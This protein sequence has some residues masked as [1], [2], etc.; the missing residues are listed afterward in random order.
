MEYKKCVNCSH[1]QQVND[2]NIY[3]D[4]AGKYTICEKCNTA[5]GVEIKTDDIYF[6]S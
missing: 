1:V 4:I 5:Y 2:K 3:Q 6:K